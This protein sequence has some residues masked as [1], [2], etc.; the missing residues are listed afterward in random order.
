MIAMKKLCFRVAAVCL[1]A[2]LVLGV[3]PLRAV[4]AADDGAASEQV[5]V[6]SDLEQE[7]ASLPT[8]LPEVEIEPSQSPSAEDV[9]EPS[10]SP[11]EEKTEEP[12]ESPSE[13]ETEEP[14]ESPSEEETEEPKETPSEEDEEGSEDESTSQKAVRKAAAATA[15][16]ATLTLTNV[17]LDIPDGVND[18]FT[19][20]IYVWTTGSD[21]S[22]NAV[23]GTYGD[24]TLTW[25]R[26]TYI[27]AN[28][29]G[30]PYGSYY[31]Y[32][33]VGQ[34]RLSAG[35]TV[36]ISG[37]PEGCGYHILAGASANYYVK[38][39][40]CTYGTVDAQVGTVYVDSA[41]GTN[42]VVCVNDYAPNS[43]QL[44][45][46][47]I[48]NDP[49]SVDD[50]FTFTIYLYSYNSSGNTPLF[51]GDSVKV[52]IATD[53]TNGAKAPVLGDG[54]TLTF[55]TVTETL[56]GFS[57]S[58]TY[59]VATVTLK[60]GQSVVL[61]HLG[62]SYGCY[63]SQA[64]NEHYKLYLLKSRHVY[65]YNTADYVGNYDDR[66]T[67]INSC[68]VSSSVG[69]TNAQEDLSIAKEVVGNDTDR[70][71]I[72]NVYLL[73]YSIDTGR[74]V[75]FGSGTYDLTYTNPTGDEA[76]TVQFKTETSTSL[77]STMTDDTGSSYSVEWV[78]A[79][80]KV[81]A[82][83]TVTIEDLPAALVYYIEEMPV[84]NYTLTNA[85]STDSST[86]IKDNNDVYTW[87]CES[88]TTITF[89]NTYT[90]PEDSVDL[91]LSKTVTGNFSDRDQAFSFTIALTDQDG[92]PLSNQDIE[93][94]LPGQTETTV[95]TT[96]A[97]GQLTVS[98]KD[99]QQVTLQ[100]LPQG[101]Q[102][103]VTE[104][105]ADQYSTSF[106]VTG[107]SADQP[108]DQTQSGA[109]DTADD[110]S[111]Q[112]TNDLSLAVPTGVRTETQSA[113]IVGGIAVGALLLL[114]ASKLKK[115]KQ[116]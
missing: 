93:V 99:G 59:N 75:S 98:L 65:Q 103:T 73:E 111:I 17:E 83:Q 113:V 36:T 28:S 95:Y 94:L 68:G 53:G 105:D 54:D 116:D 64:P 70:D 92:E 52:D 55:T 67:Y 114:I 24:L 78:A 11:S 109:L 102:Y 51:E 108:D 90:P 6:E 57:K 96:D 97:D 87:F 80:I 61:K 66:Y 72:F 40:T 60:H 107:G 37:L 30:L 20:T 104:T 50:T 89:T 63:I 18:Y 88:D 31:N 76:K 86:V 8:V 22:I 16:T 82:G 45:E 79:Q 10:E 85:T 42:E 38:N 27:D 9:E 4:Y 58:G 12:S 35:Q 5:Q 46:E 44:S 2:A 56:P 32:F 14:M 26:L 13:E 62:T 49:D 7:E 110:V 100:D 71:F 115:G 39:L 3:L 29:Y 33:G 25:K 34:V 74:Y 69:F 81:A 1:A 48:S 91:T 43:L 41:Y 47:V 19:Y 112:V 101:T 15:N 84:T 77:P 106:S 23:T 21:G